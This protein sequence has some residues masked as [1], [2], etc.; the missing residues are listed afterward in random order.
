M[1]ANRPRVAVTPTPNC[2]SARFTS[3]DRPLRWNPAWGA[4]NHTSLSHHAD[5]D[6]FS[7]ADS[8]F[9][10]YLRSIT[11]HTVFVIPLVVVAVLLLKNGTLLASPQEW[12]QTPGLGEKEGAAFVGAF[13]FESLFVLFRVGGPLLLMAVCVYAGRRGDLPIRAL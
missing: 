11:A 13:T 8:K 1:Q 4:Q 5:A 3:W 6:T 12:Y 10:R 9:P 2:I 7:D